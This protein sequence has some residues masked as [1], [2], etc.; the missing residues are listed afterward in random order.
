MQLSSR[1]STIVILGFLAVTS[2][3]AQ[4]GNATITGTITD[5]SGAAIQGAKI[6]VRDVATGFTRATVSN[7]TG[8]YNLPGLRPGVYTVAVESSGFRRYQQADFRVEVAQTARL[9]VQMQLGQ[10]TEV[11]EISASAQLLHTENATVGAVIDT[12]KE[13]RSNSGGSSLTR[14]II[15][16]GCTRTGPWGKFIRNCVER[17]GSEDHPIRS[18]ASLLIGAKATAG[19]SRY[20]TS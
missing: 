11:V 5:P 8:N 4:S 10:T 19:L 9:D 18:E 15:R 17:S 7:E 3:Q 20:E 1:F 14:S 2:L 13:R 6:D 12:K 16:T